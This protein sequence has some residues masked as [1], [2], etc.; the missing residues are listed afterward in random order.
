MQIYCP[1]CKEVRDFKI[2]LKSETYPVRGEDITIEAKVSFCID[3]GRELFNKEID[4]E[5]LNLAYSIYRK[6]HNL[7]FPERIK[8]IRNKYSLS[9][10]SLGR[11]LEWGEITVN[12][13]ESRGIQDPAHNEVLLLIDDPKNMKKIFEKQSHLLNEKTRNSL[14]KRIEDLT[15]E[16]VKYTL[17]ETLE[18]L[19]GFRVIGEFTGFKKFNLER[20]INLI[21]YVVKKSNGVFETKLNKLLW[22]IEFLY[23][24]LY[25]VSITG[26]VYQRFPYGPVPAKYKFL[27]AAAEEEGLEEREARGSSGNI[28]T[29]YFT[30]ACIES[31]Y[32]NRQEKEVIDFVI[33]HFKN[34]NCGA[35]KEKSHKEKGYKQT[36]DEEIISYY[37]FA[38]ELSI[39]LKK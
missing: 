7:L 31:S 23:F 8:A 13:Y 28:G 29:E 11:L 15:K 17:R 33:D 3:C 27:F 4:T 9:Q 25:T 38:P 24:K 22:Y 5:N 39:R 30:T 12:R 1:A 21:I 16:N 6:K 35:M 10:R 2:K 20:M 34:Y 14:K 36:K 18:T 19:L 32:F 26:S 37:K